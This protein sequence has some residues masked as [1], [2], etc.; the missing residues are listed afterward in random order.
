MHLVPRALFT[1]IHSKGV[2]RSAHDGPA[3]SALANVP[4]HF[5]GGMY[6]HIAVQIIWQKVADF[7]ASEQDSFTH[8]KYPCVAMSR[9]MANRL[10][11]QKATVSLVASM[12]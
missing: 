6:F 7:V 12:V 1:E 4:A 10:A 3:I 11:D 5:L 2:D 8:G 9:P